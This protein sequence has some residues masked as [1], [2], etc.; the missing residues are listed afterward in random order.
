MSELTPPVDLRDHV[1][2]DPSAPVTLVEF[3]DYECPF[4]GKAYPVSQALEEALGDR[5][6]FVYRHFPIAEAHPHAVLAA[7]CAEAADAQGM[8]WEMHGLLYEHQDALTWPDVMDYA[9]VLGLDVEAFEHDVRAHRFAAKLRVDRHSGA[10]SG[11]TGTPTFFING[12]R[13]DGPVDFDSL[14][15]AIVDGAGASFYGGG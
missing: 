15:T 8:F 13:Y 12:F 10:L 9:A 3:G 5:L 2:G 14:W 7:E 11:V 4:C 6:C 1:R